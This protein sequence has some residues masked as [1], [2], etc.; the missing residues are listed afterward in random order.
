[1]PDI[2][3]RASELG[4]EN[5]FVV[6]GEVAELLAQGKEIISFCIGQPDFPTPDHISLAGIRAIT[7]GHHGYTPSPGIQPLREAVA[8]YFTRTRNVEVTADGVVCG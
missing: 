1:M 5:A 3:R 6:L 8:K 4:T 7:D 2:S